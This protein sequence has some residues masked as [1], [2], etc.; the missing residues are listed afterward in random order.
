MTSKLN[1]Y[2][3]GS[4]MKGTYKQQ[5][6]KLKQVIKVGENCAVCGIPTTNVTAVLEC[7]GCQ[8]SC[9]CGP[10]CQQL[11]WP[12]HRN[13]C[14]QVQILKKYHMPYAQEIQAATIRGDRSIP[15]LEKLRTKL[16]LTR[17]LAEYKELRNSGTHHGKPID[18]Q[19]Y[20]VGRRDGTVWV[21]SDF[22]NVGECCDELHC[23]IT[24]VSG[25]APRGNDEGRNGGFWSHT[26]PLILAMVK[27]EQVGVRMMKEYFEI[28]YLFLR[29]VLREN[30]RENKKLHGVAVLTLVLMLP[31]GLSCVFLLYLLWL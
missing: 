10:K 7:Q 27:M 8:C 6:H 9:Y 5:Q 22:T 3:K 19:Q 13:D 15:P 1:A 4:L 20:L 2:S 18:P 24:R 31:I 28:G 21:G 30:V 29:H 16:G 11:H 12:S 23:C 25:L 17:P 26:T 14:K